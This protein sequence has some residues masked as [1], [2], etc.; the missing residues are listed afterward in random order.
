MLTVSSYQSQ[1][2]LTSVQTTN[3]VSQAPPEELHPADRA[4][5]SLRHR[6]CSFTEHGGCREPNSLLRFVQPGACK[7]LYSV[8]VAGDC[9]LSCARTLDIFNRVVSRVL[10]RRIYRP[11]YY[12]HSILHPVSG[13]RLSCLLSIRTHSTLIGTLFH[14][15]REPH[16]FQVSQSSPQC[17][18]F[19]S[20]SAQ[21]QLS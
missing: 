18:Q 5:T 12:Y 21:G 4:T 13:S 2:S 11:G 15:L 20:H 7:G 19:V 17:S 10:K 1:I 8:L 16:H 9:E 6:S 14:L 3:S